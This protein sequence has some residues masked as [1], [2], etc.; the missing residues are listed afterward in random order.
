MVSK[1]G[2]PCP[3]ERA[4]EGEAEVALRARDGGPAVPRAKRAVAVVFVANGFAFASWVSRVPAIRDTLGLTPGEV[5]L[6]LL[7][8]SAGTLVALPL[9]GVVVG[10][11]GPARTVAAAVVAGAVGL[12]LVAAGLTARSAVAVGAGLFSYGIGTSAWDVAMNVEGADVERRLG[13]TV[14]PRFHAGFSLGTVLGALAGAGAARAGLSLQVQ[15]VITVA[16]I[17]VA[18]LLAVRA[19]LPPAARDAET[20]PRRSVLL[21]WREPRTLAVGLLVLAFALCEGIANDWLALSLVDGYGATEAVGAV[22]F[23]TFVGAMTVARLFGGSAVERYGRAPVLRVTAVLVIVGV[24][25]VVFSSGLPGAFAGAVLWG[26]GASL[27]FPLGMSAAADDETRAAA[28]VSVVSS[29]GYTAFLAG[30]PLVGLLA[31]DVGVRRAILVAV[32]AAVVGLVAASAATPRPA[33]AP[34]TVPERA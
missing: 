2:R 27:G 21:A 31:D 17:L 1:A 9:S 28:R 19:F 20:G 5:G 29:I 11:L 22:G 15:L 6:L 8:L 24:L 25:A 32:G 13:R 34:T 23:G 7:F 33:G 10:R 4:T 30:P 18:G 14:M 3:T 12:L 16:G 26:L